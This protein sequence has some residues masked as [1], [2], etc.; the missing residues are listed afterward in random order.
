MAIPHYPVSFKG[1]QFVCNLESFR[2]LPYKDPGGDNHWVIGFGTEIPESDLSKYEGG[3]SRDT[4]MFL[5]SKHSEPLQKQL[6]KTPLVTLAQNQLDA[7]FS[8]AFNIGFQAFID[9]TIYKDLV[10]RGTDLSAWRWFNKGSNGEVMQGLVRRRLLELRLF[11]YG[12]YS[13]E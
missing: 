6:A 7:V 13:T 2:A 12:V 4:G 8:L 1:V 11:I 9:S 10:A 3:I 5:F